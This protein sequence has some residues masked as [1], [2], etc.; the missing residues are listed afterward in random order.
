M[1]HSTRQERL[2]GAR[3]MRAPEGR[4]P[5]PML[6]AM[7][8]G[9]VLLAGLLLG[10]QALEAQELHG[11]VEG[12]QGVRTAEAPRFERGSYTARESRLQL[13]LSGYGDRAE[14]FAR[15]DYYFDQLNRGPGELELREAFFVYTGFQTVDFKLGRQIM[16]WGTG[17][18]LF[19]ND[20]FPKDWQ[21]FFIGREDQYLK[22]PM[23]AARVGFYSD[24]FNANLVVMPQFEPDRLPHPRRLD[25]YQPLPGAAPPLE[26]GAEL[27]GG[28]I[29]L[30]VNRH[31]GGLEVA[32]YGYRGYYRQPL[33]FDD[34]ATMHPFY[35]RLNVYGA[36][37]RRGLLSGVGSIEAGFYHSVDDE[38]GDD[39]LV[40]NSSLRWMA[41]FDRQP[42]T[43][44]QAGIQGYFEWM[45][46]HEEYAAGLKPG[47]Y[48]TD[49]LRQLYTLRLTQWLKYQTVQLSLFAFASP[50][51]EDL[52]VRAHVSYKLS[53]PV[54]VGLGTNLFAGEH[55]E[56]MFGQLDDNDNLYLRARYSF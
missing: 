29:A 51:D 54:E 19:I 55:R 36:S 45:Q 35:P 4:R 30:R 43:D 23:D 21:S 40:P 12:L 13:K 37:L 38:D 11:F 3:P 48:E 7:G 27:D 50:T 16:T 22:A 1:T 10:S 28:E 17:D 33:G 8:R 9:L 44:F 2:D 24:L 18:L 15:V 42:W 31:F 49:E 53:D 14:Y 25:F 47:M 41:G 46:D 20:V 26:P 39:P 52:Y 32:L 34:P 6:R 56:T 5:R